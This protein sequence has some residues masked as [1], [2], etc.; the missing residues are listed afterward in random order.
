MPESERI[1]V[2]PLRLVLFPNEVLPLH[3]FEP[4]YTEMIKYCLDQDSVFGVVTEMERGLADFGSTARIRRVI[5]QY[6][7]GRL[8][9]ETTGETRF[10]L[11]EKHSEHAYLTAD[12]RYLS[13]E[14]VDADGGAKEQA[15]ALHMRLLE[16]VGD[17]IK[18]SSYSDADPV[19]FR[20]ATTAGLDIDGR[21][22]LLEMNNEVERLRY[23]IEHIQ[24]LISHIEQAKERHGR[25]SSNG[26]FNQAG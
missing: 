26:H 14:E 3:I 11:F 8:D 7:D 4:R 24:Q 20:I 18:P 19:S 13:D 22:Q 12:V 16:A 1:P 21:L 6:D 23:L 5:R 25:V 9:I 17:D 10:R 15:T 2:F